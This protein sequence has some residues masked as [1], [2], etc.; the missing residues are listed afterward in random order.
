MRRKTIFNHLGIG[1][2]TADYL[3]IMRMKKG[4]WFK[5]VW[6]LAVIGYKV[7]SLVKDEQKET[8]KEDK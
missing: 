2:Q 5:E 4:G 1:I 6:R 3:K 8:G 7:E